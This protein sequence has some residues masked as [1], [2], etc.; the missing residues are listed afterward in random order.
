M[1]VQQGHQ[2]QA[3]HTHDH[4]RVS[5]ESTRGLY[6][7]SPRVLRLGFKSIEPP[8]P[9]GFTFGS[10]PDSD[11]KVPY[12]SI[13][14]SKNL[15]KA[16]FRIHYNFNSGALLITALNKIKVGSARL[17]KQ[18]SLLLMAGQNATDHLLRPVRA[19]IRVRV[20]FI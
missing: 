10:G 20:K 12:Y 6:S 9:R 14:P 3:K 2:N 5:R 4:G 11:V 18:Q 16:Y 1:Q 15:L 17:E 8:S 7:T 19:L 13:D